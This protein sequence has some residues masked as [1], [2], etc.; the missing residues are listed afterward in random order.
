MQ[1][2]VELAVERA[3]RQELAREVIQQA[4]ADATETR[5]ISER[6]EIMK[7]LSW[8]ENPWYEIQGVSEGAVRRI[9][10]EV[11]DNTYPWYH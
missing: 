8:P 7:F 2:E 1:E 3:K 10:T 4:V 5:C 9:A 6:D 11:P